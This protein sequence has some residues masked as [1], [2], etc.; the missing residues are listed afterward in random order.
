LENSAARFGSHVALDF[1]GATTTYAQLMDQV[2]RGAEALRRLGV[3]QGDR[4]GLILPNCPQHVVAFYA[5]LRIGAIVVEHNPLYTAD[6]LAVQLA[7]HGAKVVICWEKTAET[8]AGIVGRTSV[9]TIIGV[10]LAA[11][12]P[13][14]KRLALRLPVPAARKTR[15]QM[16]G[17]LPAGSPRWE[18]MVAGTPPL[19]PA[20]PE[21]T[22]SD[23][24]LLQYTGGTTGTPKGA[25]LTHS[26]LAANAEQ[27]RVWC[28][29]I[30]EGE[31]TILAVLPLFH[32][33]GLTLC[34][35][36]AVG[37]G[38]RLVLMPRFELGPVIDAIHRCRPTFLPGVPTLYERLAVA[39][40]QGKCDLT[41][42]RFCIS[43][44]MSLPE[45]VVEQWERH[46][47]GFLVE[48]YGMT[49]TSPVAVG[50]PIST[51]RRPGSIGIPFPST[52]CKIVD[53]E[54]PSHEFPAGKPGELLIHGP[55]VMSGYWHRDDETAAVMLPGGWIRTGDLAT[56]DADGFI[57][58]VDRIKE[59][60]ITG[61]FNVYPSEVEKVLRD[62]PGVADVAVVGL[63]A[64]PS[65]E[66][67][68]AAIIADEGAVI[69]QEAVRTWCRTH[70][71][72][73]KIPRRIIVLEELPRS[74][75]GKVLRRKVRDQILDA[76][77]PGSPAP[78]R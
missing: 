10:N 5:A 29:G 33:Y 51:K 19:D 58:I 47:G 61:G 56:M 11:G 14:S 75:V 30:R 53:P 70:I 16:R 50:N 52:R 66:H 1:F 27:G 64:R 62:Y 65:G 36:F 37:L 78:P 4:V 77:T 18:S 17:S 44:A 23:V 60:I 67:V 49:E 28:H 63:P 76:P 25:V 43:G 2:L 24:A 34:L 74:Q 69:E 59:L 15:D 35:T 20:Y 71:A 38:A 6:E 57:T 73:Y 32:A 21:P 7:D 45:S 39:A 26:N 8:V 41:S 9:T 31:E 55:Q 46:A 12:L 40:E 72:G 3:A 68:A 54:D 48:G 22:V 42:I 13:L